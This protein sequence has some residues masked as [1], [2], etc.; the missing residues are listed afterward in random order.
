M[1]VVRVPD[2]PPPAQVPEVVATIGSFDG[3]HRGHRALLERV[4]ARARQLQAQT[5]VITFDPHP[6][7]VIRPDHRLQLLSVLP[8]KEALFAG[9]NVDHLLIW[10]FDEAL[11][12]T[13]PE[14][15]FDILGRYVRLKELVHG[16]GFALGRR[17]RGTPEVL[18]QI[19]RQR[20]FTVQQIDAYVA[21]AAVDH[22]PGDGPVTSTAIR[23]MIEAGEV[24]AATWALTRPPTVLGTVVGG[25]RVGRTLGF[26]T[27]NLDYDP[28][29]AVPADGVYAAWAERNPFTPSAERLP[30]AVSI[31]MRPTFDGQQRVVEA[32]LLDFS[33]DLYGERLRLHVVA[34]LRG[35]LRFDGVEALIAQ[36]HQD[37]AATRQLL[38][39]QPAE[40]ETALA[41]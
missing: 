9:L 8:E 6:R 38:E 29:Q 30:A 12:N 16:P 33:G 10:H 26:P 28:R 15:F 36:M 35:Q 13:E 5:A 17:R 31:G 20:G 7:L 25:E 40:V 23:A 41:P 14:G 24:G 34:R 19:G 27:A 32:Y 1:R 2:S 4:A 11:K 3:V 37:V 21:Q 39:A 22:Q 18:A